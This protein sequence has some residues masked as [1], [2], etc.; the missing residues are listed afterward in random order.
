MK[1]LKQIKIF[2]LILST[3]LLAPVSAQEADSNY[4]FDGQVKWMLLTDTGTLL[5]STGEALVGIKPNSSEVSFKIDRLKKVKEENLEFVP[6]TPY[7][8]IKPKG[9]LLHLRG[10][11]YEW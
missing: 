7:L 6:N 8:I 11:S 9:M 3:V 2:V 10:R 4:A 5:A 1:L